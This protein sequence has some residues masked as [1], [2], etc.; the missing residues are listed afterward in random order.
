MTDAVPQ[1]A[2]DGCVTLRCFAEAGAAA[3]RSASAAPLLIAEIEAGWAAPR[4]PLTMPLTLPAPALP[5]SDPAST[6]ASHLR[7]PPSPKAARAGSPLT[8]SLTAAGE[9][10]PPAAP[11]AFGRLESCG[12]GW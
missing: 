7:G 5:A 8:A 6:G 2:D 9:T 1:A 4:G 11:E 3:P 10:L 12:L